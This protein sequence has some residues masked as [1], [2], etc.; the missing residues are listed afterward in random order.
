ME[1]FRAI[2]RDGMK[3]Y[4][5]LTRT[6]VATS[7]M[8]LGKKRSAKDEQAIN[9]ALK[10]RGRVR[11]TAFADAGKTTDERIRLLHHFFERPMTTTRVR[12]VLL[13]LSQC[14]AARRWRKN[15]RDQADT[16]QDTLGQLLFDLTAH[17]MAGVQSTPA[18]AAFVHPG[19]ER[20][21]AALMVRTL[22]EK[23]LLADRNVAEARKKIVEAVAVERGV[24]ARAL[25]YTLQRIPAAIDDAPVTFSLGPQQP[26]T[27]RRR[28]HCNG[29]PNTD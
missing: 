13:M 20:G 26:T 1:R 7:K 28:P 11:V 5:D 19:S 29:R 18:I 21:F 23:G 27:T 3:Q 4:G 24:M 22:H 16:Y 2:V 14:D 10:P 12:Q 17:D 8:R 25:A 15:N 6:Q 9:E